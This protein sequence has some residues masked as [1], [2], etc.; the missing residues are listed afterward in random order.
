MT[1]CGGGACCLFADEEY[2]AAGPVPRTGLLTGFQKG[3]NKPNKLGQ[4][5]GLQRPG[6]SP[7]A[8]MKS[9]EVI[10]SVGLPAVLTSELNCPRSILLP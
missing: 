8:R 7:V 6:A 5:F 2:P 10:Q 9:R 3:L 1:R 4:C